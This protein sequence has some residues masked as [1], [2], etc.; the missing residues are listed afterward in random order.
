MFSGEQLF[1]KKAL[2]LG[3]GEG[4]VAIDGGVCLDSHDQGSTCFTQVQYITLY[5]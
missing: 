2:F 4:D 3:G 1:L 5:A